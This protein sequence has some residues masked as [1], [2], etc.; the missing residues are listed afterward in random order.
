MDTQ[1]IIKYLDEELSKEEKNAF[2]KKLAS[3]GALAKEV[4]AL[5]QMKSYASEK[6]NETKAIL[7][8]K[9][10][11]ESYRSKKIVESKNNSIIKYLLPLAVAAMV[12]LGIFFRQTT[13][14]VKPSNAELY[15]TYFTPNDLQIVN[16]SEDDQSLQEKAEASFNSGDYLNADVYISELMQNDEQNQNL[17][18]HKAICLIQTD[19][20]NDADVLLKT[21]LPNPLYK[22]EALYYFAWSKI[23]QQDLPKAESYLKQI[24]DQSYRHKQAQEL[25]NRL[26]Q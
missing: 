9:K 5:R 14:D 18:L 7:A 2:E 1:D 16:R 3:D 10:V 12:V 19:R 4:E 20:L 23:Q 8:S 21:L 15:A 17:K 22:N 25:L 24:G 26:I 6:A 11:H 13:N